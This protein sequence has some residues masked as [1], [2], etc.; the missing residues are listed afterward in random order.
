ML[1][2]KCWR[3]LVRAGEW[4]H[5]ARIHFTPDRKARLHTHDFPEIFWVEE[6]HGLHFINGV[7]KKLFPGDLLFVRPQDQHVL[8]ARDDGGFTLV[9]LA[10][11]LV[12]LT[13]LAKRHPA[14]AQLH[15]SRAALPERRTLTVPQIRIWREEVRRLA[16]GSRERLPLERFLLGL[17]WLASPS[18]PAL[19][20]VLPAWLEHACAQMER[21]EHFAGGTARL[22]ELC[23]RTPE[24]VARSCRKWLGVTPTEW[25]NRV[26]MEHAARELRLGARP[27][28]EI[29]L[30]C[31]F[32]NLAHF[33]ALFRSAYG[34]TPRRYRVTSQR[35][36]V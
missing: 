19:Q 22:V 21:P 26:R 30:E 11:P 6:G 25:V 33:Y 14:V 12:V 1:E 32:N 29:C 2:R 18:T 24:Y 4:F 5:L 9:N 27:I 36:V 35:S 13:D 23:G 16:S 34:E 20:P 28:L 3:E 8:R 17:Y 10:F 7:E 31:G 15:V